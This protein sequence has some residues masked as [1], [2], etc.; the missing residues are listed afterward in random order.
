LALAPVLRRTR[1]V[2]AIAAR[3]KVADIGTPISVVFIYHFG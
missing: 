2:A 1:Q 3:G